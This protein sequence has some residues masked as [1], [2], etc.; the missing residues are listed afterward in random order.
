[1]TSVD[2]FFLATMLTETVC[3]IDRS[4]NLMREAFCVVEKN[5]SFGNSIRHILAE[6]NLYNAHNPEGLVPDQTQTP[7]LDELVFLAERSRSTTARNEILSKIDDAGVRAMLSGQLQ[8]QHRLPNSFILLLFNAILLV[9]KRRIQ[10]IIE[11]EYSDSGTYIAKH[12]HL[13]MTFERPKQK[14]AGSNTTKT[15]SKTRRRH[16]H[17]YDHMEMSSA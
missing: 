15:R 17:K 7:W 1:M 8:L 4:N 9:M 10:S 16:L 13:W 6:S 14:Y 12:W 2:L 3:S 5:H 11:G